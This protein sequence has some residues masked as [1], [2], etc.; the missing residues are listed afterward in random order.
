MLFVAGERGIAQ[1]FPFRSFLHVP[2]ST[3]RIKKPINRIGAEQS[4]LSGRPIHQVKV[5]NYYT[6]RY[7]YAFDL[8]AL[9]GKDVR[10]LSLIERRGLLQQKL[11]DRN[12]GP[13]RLSEV[14]EVSVGRLVKAVRRHGLEGIVAKRADS[15]YEAGQRS[16][17]WIKF[18]TNKGQELVIGGY[19]PSG[20]SFEY[21]VA[22]YYEGPKLFFVGRLRTASSPHYKWD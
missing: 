12:R 17:A 3:R 15:R 18:K 16:G 20:S 13:V 14:F 8:L 1:G 7:F 10:S 21:L 11:A 6:S 2:N 9:D 22:G 19:K 5:I 4:A